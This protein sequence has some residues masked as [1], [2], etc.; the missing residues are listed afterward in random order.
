[1]KAGLDAAGLKPFLMVQPL[2]YH[3]PDA[4]KQGFIDLPEFPFG[5]EPRICT[6]W[7]NFMQQKNYYVVN[8]NTFAWVEVILAYYFYK[9][10]VGHT[11]YSLFFS[12]LYTN[13]RTLKYL[14]LLFIKL[15]DCS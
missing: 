3:T 12:G 5:L 1:M 13:A 14:V 4:G 15:L 8:N 2:A 11:K 9:L 6:R 7:D 10:Y